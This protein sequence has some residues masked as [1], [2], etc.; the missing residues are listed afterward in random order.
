MEEAQEL[1]KRDVKIAEN[2]IKRCITGTL[3][4][5]S[6]DALASF[7]YNVG[8]K[9]FEGS[10]LVKKINQGDMVGAAAEFG[11]WVYA[12]GQQVPGLVRRREAER[13]LFMA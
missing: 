11:K 9:A 5:N 2:S 8:T 4:Q 13:L 1:L 6:F 3:T 7:C 12:K 10:T